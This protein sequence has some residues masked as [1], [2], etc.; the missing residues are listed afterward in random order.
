MKQND[1]IKSHSGS[2][3]QYIVAEVKPDGSIVCMDASLDGKPCASNTGSG[4]RYMTT[5]IEPNEFGYFRFEVVG[6]SD[7]MAVAAAIEI[8]QKHAD[9]DRAMFESRAQFN[10]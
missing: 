8:R 4:P 10:Q 7:P 6:I 1:I 3:L 2:G 9:A 5:T